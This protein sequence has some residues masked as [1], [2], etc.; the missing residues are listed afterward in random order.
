MNLY[1]I[2]I[3]ISLTLKFIIKNQK[4]FKDEKDKKNKL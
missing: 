1:I 4:Y 2:S 3:K